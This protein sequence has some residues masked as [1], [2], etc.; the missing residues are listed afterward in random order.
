MSDTVE[1]GTRTWRASRSCVQPFAR[2]AALTTSPNVTTHPHVA[3]TDGVGRSDIPGPPGL[4]QVHNMTNMRLTLARMRLEAGISQSKLAP[5]LGLSRTHIVGIEAGTSD[6]TLAVAERWAAAC[7][8]TWIAVESGEGSIGARVEA[9][10]SVLPDV[11][12][13]ALSDQIS[14]LE[15]RYLNQ[16]EVMAAEPPSP[17]YVTKGH[18]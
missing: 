1:R 15:L 4:R 17:P 2:R 8:R 9:L 7:G 14:S 5:R 12:L 11:L 18:E 6:T 16:P 10:A 13:E 3:H